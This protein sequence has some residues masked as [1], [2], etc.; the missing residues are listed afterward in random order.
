MYHTTII[1]M[2]EVLLVACPASP[3]PVFFH[4][5]QRPSYVPDWVT[6][7]FPAHL[8]TSFSFHHKVVV[9][10]AGNLSE[11]FSEIA[12][13]YAREIEQ[14]AHELSGLECDF[15]GA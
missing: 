13:A 2:N 3:L 12:E 5:D 11:V 4:P 1:P 10:F 14:E 6:A 9:A 15:V 8:E 7:I